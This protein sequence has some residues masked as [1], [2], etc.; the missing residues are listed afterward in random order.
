MQIYERTKFMEEKFFDADFDFEAYIQKRLLEIEDVG[1]RT[2]MKQLMEKVMLPFYQNTEM[3][4]Q[5]L[6]ERVQD[7]IFRERAFRQDCDVVTS[8]AKRQYVDGTDRFLFPMCAEDLVQDNVSN[9]RIYLKADRA[10]IERLKKE[11]RVFRGRIC[12]E[13]GEYEAAFVLS[14]VDS[15]RRRLQWLYN[16]FVQNGQAWKSVCAP[17]LDCRRERC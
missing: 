6:V 8:I 9:P 4:Y 17:H 15:Y 7:E 11:Q 2:A 10:A 14:P 12:S 16:V 3:Q 5:A 1:D 13:R